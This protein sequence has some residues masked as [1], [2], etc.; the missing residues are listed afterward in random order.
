MKI[1]FVGKGGSG[2]TTLSALFCRHLATLQV[3][4][5]AF[6]AD[7][8]QHLG[9]ALGLAEDE[10][11]GIPALGLEL[12]RI[13][14][15]LRG[16]N[17]R[18]SQA[19]AMTKTTPPGR[20]SRLWS[21]GEENALLSYFGRHIKGVTLLV[22][23]PFQEQDL[24][25]RCYHSKVGAV[26][27]LL[28]HCLDTAGEYIIV[29]MTAGADTFASGLFTRFDLTFL[30]V[31]P[32]RQ[33]LGVYRQY[34]EYARDYAVKLCVIANKIETEDD[35]EF[36]REHVGNDLVAWIGR[37][38]YVR[39]MEKGSVVPFSSLEASNH[40]ALATMKQVVDSC[41]QDWEKF[42]RQAVEFHRRNALAWMNVSMGEDVTTQIDPDFSLS[43][44][45]QSASFH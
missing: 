19:S 20:G 39:S 24:G 18:I 5:L 11:A 8:N 30:V 23:G 27:L 32:T 17:P 28:N 6:D 42:Y 22:T 16:T 14:D 44:S 25:L 4:T 1:A 31:E 29:D 15:Y 12:E 33:S 2:K 45:F 7:I 9:E 35:L 21:V 13:K 43:A 38:D 40:T 34:T 37:S 26:E 3:P 36:V 10:L 41:P